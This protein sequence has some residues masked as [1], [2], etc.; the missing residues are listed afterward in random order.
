MQIAVSLD[1]AVLAL[2]GYVGRPYV[3][4]PTAGVRDLSPAAVRV[5]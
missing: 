4:T 2:T 3:F 1:E 5:P